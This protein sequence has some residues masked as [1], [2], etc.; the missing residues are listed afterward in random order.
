MKIRSYIIAVICLLSVSSCD[1]YLTKNPISNFNA[2]SFYRSQ[3]DFELAINGAYGNLRSTTT[4]IILMESRSDNTKV[5]QIGSE[6]RLFA[7]MSTFTETPASAEIVD[8]WRSFWRIVSQTNMILDRIDQGAFDDE[9]VRARIKGEA[10]FLRGLAYFELGWLWGGVPIVEKEVT[11]QE[12]ARTKRSSQDET[13]SF[14]EE[15]LINASLLLPDQMTGRLLGKATRFAAEGYLARLYMFRSQFDKAVPRLE[16][17]IASGY[18]DLFDSYQDAF[19]E[20]HDNGKEHL[21]QIQYQSGT[22]GHGLNLP[23]AMFGQYRHEYFPNGSGPGLFISE[24]LYKSFEPGDTRRDYSIVRGLYTL[25][26]ILNEADMLPIKFAHGLN[27]N[28][29]N[30]YGLNFPLLRYSDILLMYSEALNEV[31]QQGNENIGKGIN[32]LRK[33]ASLDPVDFS[34]LSREEILEVI[35]RE[36]RVEFAFEG[37]RW[38]DLI[39]TKKVLSVMDMFLKSGENEGLTYGMGE[40][41]I[42]M[43]IPQEEFNINPDREYMWQNPGYN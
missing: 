9:N 6:N 36:R 1:D 34:G 20:V 30:T 11:P 31:G 8:F 12:L 7:M 13:L 43:P 18:Y 10:Y 33:R 25:S 29:F 16:S 27:T 3:I 19:S 22:G 39:R 17:I 21:F 28:N 35:L 26:G 2:G 41:H 15:N 14:A 42:L 23:H 37:L 4:K 24:D 32:R 38:F 5:R 40:H